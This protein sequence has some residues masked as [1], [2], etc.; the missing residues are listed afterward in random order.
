[1]RYIHKVRYDDIAHIERHMNK[2]WMSDCA[3]AY[4]DAVVFIHHKIRKSVSSGIPVDPFDE[5]LIQEG[6]RQAL[7]AKKLLITGDYPYRPGTN[8]ERLTFIILRDT[9]LAA[10]VKMEKVHKQYANVDTGENLLA[11][12]SYVANGY[13]SS[14]EVEPALKFVSYMETELK[15]TMD[16]LH[17]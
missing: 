2:E 5:T 3:K 7:T 13:C 16:Q 15:K 6:L 11:F 4:K 1:M 8:R 12:M 17:I 10:I 9:I 14:F